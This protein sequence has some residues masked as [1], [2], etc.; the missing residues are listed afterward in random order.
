VAA[1]CAG[2]FLDSIAFTL[3]GGSLAVA[4][5][6]LA[7]LLSFRDQR[8]KRQLQEEQT[9]FF[10]LSLDMLCVAGMD[11][12]FKR[13]NPAWQQTLGFT[14]EELCSRP[15][16]EFVHPEDRERTVREIEHQAKGSMVLSFENR[17]LCKDGSYRW[18]SW[19]S[20]PHNGLMYAVARDVTD[21]KTSELELIDA[22]TR[23]EEA[24]RAKSSFLANMS[25]EI[26]TPINGVIGMTGL[27]LDT[28][29][30][31][32]QRD[33]AENIRRAA[34]ALLTVIN[35]ILDF[36]KVEA[37]KLDI[38]I[39]EFDLEQLVRH[40]EK[41]LSFAAKQKRLPVIVELRS[42][43]P[44]YLKGDPGRVRQVLT[45]LLSNAIKFT[46]QGKVTLTVEAVGRESGSLRVRFEIRDTGPGISTELLPRLFEAF[47]Q[48]DS[49]TSRRFGGTGL[50]LSISKK[51]VELMHG[52]I[53]VES[54]PGEGSLFWFEL[55]LG[56]SSH[57]VVLAETLAPTDPSV[58]K[59]GR[60]LV[61]DD[62]VM[63]QKI[64]IAQLHKLGYHADA[65]ANGIE[66]LEVLKSVPYDLILM[67]GQMPELDGLETTL[68]IRNSKSSPYKDIPIIAMTAN[69]MRGD[70]ERCLEVGMNDYVAKPIKLKELSEVVEKWIAN[71]GKARQP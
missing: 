34:D 1:L 37:G 4:G 28:Q 20:S 27:L 51:L 44:D 9:R 31:A 7:A 18:L 40:T 61:A 2:I 60:V 47:S 5:T 22:K 59:S 10:T 6:A 16:M 36:S 65:V 69:A 71:K 66:V 54:Q 49:S 57:R 48:A 58:R 64:A 8:L 12:Y 21:A 50:G 56:V 13:M 55:P 43:F 38:E 68:R 63:N 29:L 25:H 26:R 35:D 14:P 30:E 19:K 52:T 23:A 70:R 17:Y 41:G 62:N 53:G 3:A 39:L 15:I 24:T 33:Y 11:G 45:N 46:Q 42:R 67:D 32:E